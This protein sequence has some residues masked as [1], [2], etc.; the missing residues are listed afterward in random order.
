MVE[1][2]FQLWMVLV[3]AAFGA[4]YLLL[5]E[6]GYW[7]NNYVIFHDEDLDVSRFPW[8]AGKWYWLRRTWPVKMRIP[9]ARIA[10]VR[11]AENGEVEVDVDAQGLPSEKFGQTLTVMFRPKEIIAVVNEIQR[12]VEAAKRAEN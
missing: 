6:G 9:Y 8:G 12:S 2:G 5:I 7:R 3:M 4:G 1:I 11:V 10:D